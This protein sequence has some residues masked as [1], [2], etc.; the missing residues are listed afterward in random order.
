[1]KVHTT[2]PVGDH[3]DDGDG[4][5]ERLHQ[6][7]FPPGFPSPRSPGSVPHVPHTAPAQGYSLTLRLA[8]LFAT[9]STLILLALGAFVGR[10]VE[11][12]FEEGDLVELHGKLALL[13]HAL[14][15]THSA[16][17]YETLPRRLDD[18]LVGQPHLAV[19][20]ANEAGQIRYAGGAGFPAWLLT[21]MPAGED[22]AAPPAWL[23]GGER[24][25]GQAAMPGSVPPAGMAPTHSD[26]TPDTAITSNAAQRG[27]VAFARDG[28]GQRLRVA[29]AL[30]IAHH[31]TF[32]ATFERSLWLAIAAAV[33]LN[34]LFAWLAA[35]R[36]LAPLGALA[37]L[38][39]DMS[40]DTLHRRLDPATLPPELRELATAF[41]A[42]LVRLESSFERLASFSSD[43]AHE[44]RTPLT[45]L[46]T[47]AQVAL[48]RARSADQYRE[49]LYA[50]LEEYERLARMI[51]D[52]LFLA[53]ADHG[54]LV[55]HRERVDLAALV[56]DLCDFYGVLGDEHHVRLVCSGTASVDGDALMLRRAIGNLLSNALRHTADGGT[57]H[58]ALAV[59]GAG[60]TVR[61]CNP[62]TPIPA[63][64]RERI[65]ERFHRVDPARE[66]QGEGAGLGLAITASLVVAHGGRVA[67]EVDDASNTF[68]IELPAS[69]MR[70]GQ[71]AASGG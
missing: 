24:H 57:V 11:A 23:G 65:F 68:V 49:V 71:I 60:C 32:M 64:H 47:Q 34:A 46:M 55:P 17:D 30:S 42:M 43:L 37:R 39:R 56:A 31:R 26:A 29:V 28:D 58:I 3:R 20:I 38:A 25:A 5:P 44:L 16:A 51:G 13:R 54:L 63:A 61:I 69:R 15:A 7:D 1:M 10:A 4:T 45:A 2:A 36:G 40:S 18:A 21:L 50:S 70:A 9:L 66:R 53:Q 67:L 52:M 27:L 14:A 8:L 12:H 48:G 41:N 59:D 6:P 22:D 19:G 33:V 35:R 62:G